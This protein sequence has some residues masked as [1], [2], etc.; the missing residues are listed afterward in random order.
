MIDLVAYRS[1][2][3]YRRF[4]PAL[5]SGSGILKLLSD[6]VSAIGSL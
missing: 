5:P 6:R 1:Q 4:A 3:R 2:G